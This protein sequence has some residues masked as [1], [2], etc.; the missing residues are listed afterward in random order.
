ME[1]IRQ[2]KLRN[3]LADILYKVTRNNIA[4][5]VISKQAD[6]LHDSV[7]ILSKREYERM[8]EELNLNTRLCSR[9]NG[10]FD[11]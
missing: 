6:S 8:F 11:G 5:E 9:F 3:K 2:T 1:T 10:K 4:I 7:V